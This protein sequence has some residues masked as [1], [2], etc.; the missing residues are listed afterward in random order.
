MDKLLV[1]GPAR[2]GAGSGAGELCRLPEGTWVWLYGRG[3]TV[4]PGGAC[5]AAC[6][7]KWMEVLVLRDAQRFAELAG[8][9]MARDPYSTNVIGVQLAIAHAAHHSPAQDDIWVAVLKHGEVAGVAMHTP[10]HNLFLPRLKTGTAR[11]IAEVL[12]TSNRVLPGVTGEAATVEEFVRAWERQTGTVS[13]LSYSM[14]MYRL[15]AVIAPHG[16]R[17]QPRQAGPDDK[18]LLMD[19]LTQFHDEA[20]PDNPAEDVPVAVERRLAH[21]QTWLWCVGSTPVSMAGCSR[22]A[23]GLARVGPVYTPPEQ[24]RHGFGGAVTAHATQAAL[25]AGA[26]QVALYADLA[27]PT[28]N[29]I[30]QGIGYLPDHDAEERRFVQRT[31]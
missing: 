20:V 21:S 11:H 2:H 19:W 10:P 13:L 8:P 18:D 14:R 15:D 30:Y 22:P 1:G 28:S 7:L 24:R 26:A 17:G 23:A 27:N 4:I 29:S 12:G 3:V 16:V 6:T 9:W 5:L 25:E 31:Q